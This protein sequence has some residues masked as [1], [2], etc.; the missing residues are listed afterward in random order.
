MH[1]PLAPQHEVMLPEWKLTAELNGERFTVCTTTIEE[2]ARRRYRTHAK[3]GTAPELRRRT[4]PT[5]RWVVVE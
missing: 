2:T 1:T 5:S 3:I 4:A